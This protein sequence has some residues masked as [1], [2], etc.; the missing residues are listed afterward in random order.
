MTG[1]CTGAARP[2]ET[3]TET[4]D[5]GRRLE[6]TQRSSRGRPGKSFDGREGLAITE[7]KPLLENA[8]PA[9]RPCFRRTH[10]MIQMPMY[11]LRFEPIYQYR[12]WG[13]RRL[14]ERLT[15]PLPPTNPS[16]KP[17]F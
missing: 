13:G 8:P 3:A 7:Q 12:I 9:D 17:G 11:P 5:R 14:A 1:I 4:S 15:A 2:R 16:A 10:E 6:S